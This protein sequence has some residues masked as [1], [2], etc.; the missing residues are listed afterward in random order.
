M[1][2]IKIIIPCL[3]LNACMFGTSKNA[4]FYT[5]TATSG[6]AI[7]V[8]Y[9]AFVGVNRGQLPKYVDRPQMVTQQ[10]ESLQINISE[11]NRWIELPSVL[12]TRVVAENLNILLPAAQIKMNQSKGEAF[13]WIVSVEII[14]LNAVLGEEAELVA[15]YTIKNNSKK[16]LTQQKFAHTVA[17]GKTY[18]DLANGYSQLLDELSQEIATAL[19]KK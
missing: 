11:Y 15:W 4:K 17:I 8:D 9:N 5:L 14:K 7:S 13:D 12:A 19:I 10:K 3:L 18:D 6:P 16:L 2:I 1:R